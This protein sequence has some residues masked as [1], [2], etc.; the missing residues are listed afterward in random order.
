[1]LYRIFLV[2][3]AVS[4]WFALAAQLYII[5]RYRNSSVGATVVQY[6]SY[7]TILTNLMIAWVT[8][9]LFIRREDTFKRQKML[10]AILVYIM[11]VGLTYNTILRSLW[12][13]QGLQLLADNLLHSI[14][15]VLYLIF[16]IFFVRKQSLQWKDIFQWLIYP[17]VYL[18]Y[19]LIR[20]AYFGVYPYPF[21]DV[22]QLGYARVMLNSLG[23]TAMILLFSL[24]FVGISKLLRKSQI[25]NL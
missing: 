11:T 16:W 20:G 9:T 19:V 7:Y 21:V 23:I 4:A 12:K 13:P 2:L 14:I 25:S 8:T 22:E 17:L 18:V 3:L 15:P 1:M 10:T 24:L 5:I 6:F